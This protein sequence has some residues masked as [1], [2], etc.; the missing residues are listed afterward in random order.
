MLIAGQ[1]QQKLCNLQ[2]FNEFVQMRCFVPRAIGAKD[3]NHDL[4]NLIADLRANRVLEVTR[5][6]LY[7]VR[8]D[9]KQV[10]GNLVDRQSCMDGHA[11]IELL[12]YRIVNLRTN[13]ALSLSSLP[14]ELWLPW[15]KYW[16]Q[17]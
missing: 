14:A 13:R 11:E 12:N 1:A 7:E 2:P 10:V 16:N 5:H 6:V 3:E 17:A 8:D 4:D 9:I 15:P